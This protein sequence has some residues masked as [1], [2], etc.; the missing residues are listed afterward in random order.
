MFE[1]KHSEYAEANR[2]RK[3]EKVLTRSV[4]GKSIITTKI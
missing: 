3:K 4:G 2:L 1:L